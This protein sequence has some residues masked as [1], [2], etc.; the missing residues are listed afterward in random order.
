[1]IHVLTRNWWAV[2]IRGIVA[3]LFGI[4][5]FFIPG[6]TFFALVVLFGAYA[7]IDGIFALIAAVRAAE[8]HTRWGSLAAEGIIGIIIAAITFFYPGITALSLVYVIAIWAILTGIFELYAAFQLRQVLKNEVWLIIA[9]ILSV[10]FGV[11][12]AVHPGSGA[13]AIVWLIGVYA[14]IFGITMLGLA[15]RL[16]SHT[17]T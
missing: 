10:V 12:I 14:I 16:R 7:L 8:A 6:A 9:G 5:A 4:V 2:L 13:L 15:F 11:L 1:M 17:A 3:I